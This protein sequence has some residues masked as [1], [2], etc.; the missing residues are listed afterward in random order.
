MMDLQRINEVPYFLDEF[1]K[2]VRA[3]PDSRM[4]VDETDPNG[5]TRS[6][7]EVLSGRVYAW[8]TKKGIGREDFVLVCMQRG[9]GAVVAMIGTWK[10]G[11]ALTVVE[12]NYAAERIEFIR[13]DCGCKAVIDQA[14]WQEIQQT[15]Y[16]EGYVK[17]DPRD[18]AFAVYTSGSSGTPKGALHEYGNI[19]L[20]M[21]C[22]PTPAESVT[23]CED[24]RLGLIAPLNFV[25]STKLVLGILYG[26]HC[27]CIIPYTVAKN[28]IRLKDFFRQEKITHA[29]LSPSMIRVLG[30]DF[31]PSLKVVLTGGEP[32]NG[33]FIEGVELVNNYAMS[34]SAFNVGRFIMTR[35]Y[36]VCPVGKPHWDGVK[37]HLLDSDDQKVPEGESGE[38]CFENPFFRG[39]IH[40]PE[41]TR[42]ALRGGLFH[43]GDIG[44]FDADGN[45]IL[46]G[47]ANDMIKINGNRIEPAEIE[48]VFKELTGH[49][50]CAA[51]GFA[52]RGSYIAL[53]YQGEL[54]KDP[55]TLKD[56]MERKL[57]YYM[58]PSRFMKLDRIP[59]LPNGKLDRKSLPEPDRQ[60]GREEYAAPRTDLEKKLCD[61]FAA[62]LKLDRVGIKDA[63]YELG[64]DSISA[65][66]VLALMDLD[67]LSAIDLFQGS[68]AERIASLYEEKMAS[69][70]RISEEEK[71][72]R[73]RL[74]PHALTPVQRNVINFQLVWPK[75][76]M[77]IFPFLF[78]FGP[79]ADQERVL[80]AAKKIMAWHPIFSTIFEFSGDGRLQQR[81]DASR[82]ADLVIERM[83]DAELEE[84][85]N[86]DFPYF[87]LLGELMVRVRLIV[88][89]SDTCLLMVFH[90]LV[91]D[92]SSLQFIFRN[93]IHAWEGKELE[94]DTYYSYLEDE[95]RADKTPSYREAKKY[96]EDHYEGVDWCENIEPDLQRPGNIDAAC[97]IETALTP[98]K[99]R[100]FE[101]CCGASRNGFI[102]AVSC[103]ALASQT[104]KNDVL[105]SFAFNNRVDKRK[106][107]AGGLLMRTIPVGIRLDQYENMAEL[108]EGIRRQSADG[109]GNCSYDWVIFREIPYVNDVFP[110][111]YETASITGYEFL[112]EAGVSMLPLDA[113]NKASLHRTL[114]QVFETA[115]N[116][117]VS[118]HYMA[119]IYSGEKI[120]DYADRFRYFADRLIDVEDPKKIRVMDLLQE[121]NEFH[122]NL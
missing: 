56:E 52:S 122:H 77:W 91:M 9:I 79:H 114:L 40:Q 14:A 36:D 59:L 119:T 113:H 69:S 37:V 3:Y 107:T 97:L 47:R 70:E 26:I 11:A 51:K 73:A 30:G 94:L 93:L 67:D 46:L 106:Q 103:L 76:P 108:Y 109:I 60:A 115:E 34:E 7:V 83:R 63:F 102:S 61:A 85:K 74:T 2:H 27:L 99:F 95:D 78:S 98:E 65:M 86:G 50:W 72:K 57:P 33:I 41:E 55:H 58:I 118:L 12:E 43:S 35:E 71:E 81:Y 90:H 100:K 110:V 6:Q 15:D 101:A 105:I 8:L 19:K 21:L 96:Y 88:T 62:V 117:T 121:W 42:R 64:G 87:K 116:I 13:K 104:G 49:T 44:K 22:L 80:A 112:Q 17:A 54:K 23:V 20:N 53:Y 4:L 10:A 18:A 120:A 38:I 111:V 31:S 25:A 68:T 48:A 24:C 16:R 39:Y 66:T 28:P 5:L 29:F 92:G 75:A 1:A 32:A 45:L 89:E 84:L 82:R